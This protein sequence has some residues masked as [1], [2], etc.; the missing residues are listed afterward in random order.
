VCA[1]SITTN[2]KVCLLNSLH[3]GH[4]PTHL[5]SIMPTPDD[6]LDIVEAVN[7]LHLTKDDGLKDQGML[8]VPAMLYYPDPEARQGL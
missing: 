3:K 5:P 6:G 1:A 4:M 7:Y 2:I 8:R